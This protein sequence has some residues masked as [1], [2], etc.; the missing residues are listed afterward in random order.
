M[1][2][3]PQ[4]PQIQTARRPAPAADA[5]GMPGIERDTHARAPN[6]RNRRHLRMSRSA[7]SEEIRVMFGLEC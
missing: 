6:L 4:M 1:A 5:A 2:Q 7:Q 3:M